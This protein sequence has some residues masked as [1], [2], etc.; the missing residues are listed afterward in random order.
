MYASPAITV[1]LSFGIISMICYGIYDFV[2]A[3]L[4]RKSGAVAVAF[5]YFLLA[6]MIFSV[7]GLVFFKI[8]KF[9][10][11]DVVVFAIASVVS[12]F[13]LVMFYKGLE[14]GLVSVVVPLANAWAVVV[15]LVGVLFL[16]E[17][18]GLP[19]IS[20]IAAVIAGTVVISRSSSVN[21]K[22]GMLAAGIGYAVATMLGWGIFFSMIGILSKQFGWIW[23]IL[24]TS[25]GSAVIL[26][27]YMIIIRERIDVKILPV[28]T[29]IFYSSVGTLAF[30]AYSVGAER[31]YVS[32]VSP[33]A[34]SSPVV[35]LVL[36][37]VFLKERIG[38]VRALGV[39]LV[40]LGILGIAL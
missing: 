33:V 15:V 12:A 11:F 30:A 5:W 35:A 26:F 28:K 3:P 16:A 13:S 37:R 40:L 14:T 29:F 1:G 9:S 38:A 36:A 31:G 17:R 8:P 32:I 7:I 4:T 34:A 39:F 20:G 22:S 19:Q 10:L 18:V 23:P 21:K 6:S 27:F 2:S 24:I 25:I